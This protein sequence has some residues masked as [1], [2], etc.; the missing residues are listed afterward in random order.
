MNRSN[1][2]LHPQR[3]IL[4]LSLVCG[5][6]GIVSAD[7]VSSQTTPVIRILR[8]TNPGGTT[9]KRRDSWYLQSGDIKQADQKCGVRQGEKFFVSSIVSRD[10]SQV[11]SPNRNG[12]RLR[13]YWEV[14]FEKPLPC[15]RQG[16]TWFIFKTHVQQLQAVTVR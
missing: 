12:E 8:V 13:D 1:Q 5:I 3:L 2:K 4:S 6:L 16:D 15:N 9:F 7:S 14:G 10:D 11:V